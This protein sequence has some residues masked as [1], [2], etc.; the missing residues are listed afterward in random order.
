MKNI[1]LIIQLLDIK[2]RKN[3][4]N[5]FFLILLTAIIDSIGVF[6]VFPFV[7]LLMNP[8][9][10][11]TNNFF[12][13]LY[14]K[15]SY[16]NIQDYSS[17]LFVFGIIVFFFLITSLLI[18]S[19]TQFYQ[20]RFIFFQEH[21]LSKR[22]MKK[23]LGQD[24][25]WFLNNNSSELSRSIISEISSV[26]NLSLASIINLTAQIILAILIISVLMSVELIITSCIF[27]ILILFYFIIFF[28]F[29]K[30]ITIFGKARLS[31]DKRRFYELNEAFS[32]IKIVKLK[33]LEN[34]FLHNFSEA[35]KEYADNASVASLIGF[36][37]KYFIEMIVFGGLIVFSLVLILN[38]RSLV[39][40]IPM[41]S[42]YAFAGY[43]LIPSLQQIYSSITQ[44]RF[45]KSMLINLHKNLI[46]LDEIKLSYNSEPKKIKLNKILEL[47]NV[48][49]NYPNTSKLILNNVNLKIPVY[50]KIGIIGSSGSGKTTLLDLI[51]GLLFP[52]SGS[53]FVDGVQINKKNN[54]YW[55]KNLG[56]V[57][58]DVY[59]A[60]AS[61]ALNIA[62]GCTNKNIDQSLVQKAAKEANIHDFIISLPNSYN[63]IVGERGVRFSGGE[64][65]RIAIARALYN[66]PDVLVLDEATS[67]LDHATEKLI[68]DDIFNNNKNITIIKVAHRLN[69][70]QNC[71]LIYHV[72]NRSIK[73]VGQYKDIIKNNLIL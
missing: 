10:V 59:L 44:F 64:K 21:Y 53:L 54:C 62:F 32:S 31:S 42:L 38:E 68:M 72:K 43:R 61:I 51:I 5:L 30:K 23:Y 28:I 46:S 14:A 71:D 40:Y 18:R 33:S 1:R 19:I 7:S 67:S 24:Y 15:A 27:L 47:R 55:Q 25:S 52:S 66:R 6:S 69:T 63:T 34:I 12:K 65:Q 56:Y 57:A 11:E 36:L 70:L 13:Y 45:S 48:S 39:N 26:V 58:Q 16:I 35:S 29:K 50:K 2:E 17:F 41:I 9:F 60:D 22:L 4:I 8:D 37:P 20:I 3:A 73:F 49:F